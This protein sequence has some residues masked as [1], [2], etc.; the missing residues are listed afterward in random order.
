[1]NNDSFSIEEIAWRDN[2][3]VFRGSI[4]EDMID[5][6][7]KAYTFGVMPG[8]ES[9]ATEQEIREMAERVLRAALSP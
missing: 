3:Y 5:R 9:E 2:E 4:T 8:D 7:A 1:M 6:A